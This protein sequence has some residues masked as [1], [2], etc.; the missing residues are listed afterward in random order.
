MEPIVRSIRHTALSILSI[1][2][3]L[4]L[5]VYVAKSADVKAGTTTCPASGSKAIATS[6]IR[7]QMA[8]VRTLVANTGII[9]LGGSAITTSNGV[10][11]YGGESYTFPTQGNSSP[12]D[13]SRIYFACSV[14]TDVI[15]YTY[16]Q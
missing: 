7:V 9:Y 14:N 10:F 12:Y 11:L 15:N 6:S 1:T 2:L 16:A 5:L 3:G 8:T 13:L 4:L